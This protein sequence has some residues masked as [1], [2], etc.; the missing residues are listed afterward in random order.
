MDIHIYHHFPA[1]KSTEG[2]LKEILHNVLTNQK[3]L[4]KMANELQDATTA[5]NAANSKL[6]EQ[7]SV[8]DLISTKNGETGTAVAGLRV[9]VT[10]LKAKIDELIANGGNTGVG[11]DELVVKKADVLALQDAIASVTANVDAAGTSIAAVSD[12]ASTV[13]TD[14]T[15]L[16]SETV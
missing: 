10:G 5:L 9:D 15:E 11:E 4:H 13:A 6:S 1:E 2:I 7:K 12:A 8:L 16:D 14:A 3:T